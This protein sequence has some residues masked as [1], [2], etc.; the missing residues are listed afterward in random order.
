MVNI[1][2]SVL[3]ISIALA[4]FLCMMNGAAAA[5]PYYIDSWETFYDLLDN[6]DL[7]GDY[8]LTADLDF[9]EIV[10]EV[11]YWY[12]IGTLQEQFTGTFDGYCDGICGDSCQ[13]HKISNLILTNENYVAGP[14]PFFGNIGFFGVTYGATIS[15][16]TLEN[17]MLTINEENVENTGLISHIG[18]LAGLLDW[19]DLINC[20]TSGEISISVAD[21]PG[22]TVMTIGGMVGE[23]FS[24]G[25]K[26]ENCS[27]E[28]RISIESANYTAWI[29]GLAGLGRPYLTI[30][31][32]YSAMKIDVNTSTTA[33]NV[34]GIA[35]SFFGYMNNCYMAEDITITAKRARGVGG[36]GGL[37][38]G[39]TMSNCYVTGDVIVKKATGV[40][41]YLA[42]RVGGIAGSFYGEMVNCY[43]LNEK[44]EVNFD[45]DAGEANF[46]GRVI[47]VYEPQIIQTS[48]EVPFVALAA[49]APP[50]AGPEVISNEPI[51]YYWSGIKGRFTYE[52]VY[53]APTAGVMPLVVAFAEPIS[54]GLIM[55]G[56]IPS[57]AV[58]NKM[59]W[60]KGPDI[61]PMMRGAEEMWK[62]NDYKDFILPV[63]AWQ[64]KTLVADASHLKP[65]DNGGGNGTGQ[66]TVVGPGSPTSDARVVDPRSGEES[67]PINETL[68][69]EPITKTGPNC[70]LLLLIFILLIIAVAYWLYRRRQEET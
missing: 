31:N 61:R 1:S 48:I 16:L 56:P 25:N 15:N 63:F 26:I 54:V 53:E 37:C 28:G 40:G 38:P 65:A 18:L 8:I 42:T 6:F 21:K 12:P 5:G 19:T 62:M 50:T 17:V 27:S 10:E 11:G 64:Q 69:P 22:I 34:G 13:G 24:G 41:T 47:G 9:N 33:E 68:I 52:W 44:V 20:H 30:E 43:A 60:I 3:M 4:V 7:D 14:A 58:W 67:Q 55:E 35:G 70:W 46:I 66:A 29:G 51:N 45:F 57:S 2:K 59:D 49:A 23:S 32:C 39:A 36:I